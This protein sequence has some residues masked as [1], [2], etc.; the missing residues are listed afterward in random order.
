MQACIYQKNQDK[1]TKNISFR[2]VIKDLKVH[3]YVFCTNKK[4]APPLPTPKIIEKIEKIL[5]GNIRV[6]K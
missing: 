5:S 1:N 4:Y 3:H 6:F 2:K